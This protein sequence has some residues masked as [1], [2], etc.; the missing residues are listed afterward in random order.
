MTNLILRSGDL[1]TS[2]AYA[3]MHGVNCSSVM[4]AGIAPL[5]KAKFEG[6]FDAYV[7]A[8]KSGELVPG[9]VFIWS[10]GAVTVY[11][12]ASQNRPGADASLEWLESS[13]RFALHDA[14]M[15][16]LE[17]I[18]LPRIG[19]GIGGL[20]WADVEPLLRKL[21]GEFRTDLEVWTL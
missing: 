19:C 11:N 13:V 21:A 9:G 20:D 18:A 16:E 12:A 17:K 14:D 4:G 3:L 7:K 15:W 2:D 1:F 10:V 6:M 5:F 8:C